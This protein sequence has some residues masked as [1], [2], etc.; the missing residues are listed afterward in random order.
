MDPKIALI[1][2]AAKRVGAAIARELAQ[3]G[4]SV[5]IH[6]HHSQV[7]AQCLVD[8]IKGRGGKAVLVTSDLTTLE[9]M[10]TTITQVIDCL[11]IP[12]LLV[13]NASLFEP[14]DIRTLTSDLFDR[15]MG[16]HVKAPLFLSKAF[17]AALPGGKKGHIVNIIDQR[18]LKPT[19]QFYSYS[20]SKAALW[21]ATQTMAQAFAPHIRVNA[22]APGPALASERQTTA[23]FAKQSE[24][25]IL[26]RGP[27]LLEFAATIHWLVE[28]SSVT[29]QL[30]ALDGGQHL[31]WETP[32]VV[33]IDE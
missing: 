33:G 29:G 30:I 21:Y 15:H 20:L 14:D 28:T 12:T 6:C 10:T 9:G 26:G 22:I 7:E 32:D 25:V 18:V 31:A 27:D 23:D 1:T 2:G 13:N 24:A 5:A 4:W 3:S 16:I 8:D 11:G 19:P 17:A